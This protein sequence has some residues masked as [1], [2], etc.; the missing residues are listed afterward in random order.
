[1]AQGEA[2]FDDRSH[3][4][5]SIEF[6]RSSNGGP[7][8]R[9]HEDCRRKKR[10][11][12]EGGQELMKRFGEA[13]PGPTHPPR[14]F[15][16]ICYQPLTF[17]M[18][19]NVHYVRFTD[20]RNPLPSLHLRRKWRLAVHH[21][22]GQWGHFSTLRRRGGIDDPCA[23]GIG[24]ASIHASG[25]YVANRK[26]DPTGTDCSRPTR[27]RLPPSP[28]ALPAPSSQIANLTCWVRI[29]SDGGHLRAAS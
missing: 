18:S 15:R 22:G 10:G 7:G 26:P 5:H 9:G 4:H 2:R 27:Y 1:V 6:G 28:S 13:T 17:P 29:A 21:N 16:R 3:P 8:N 25:A 11:S 12:A 19:D 23:I 24:Q 14:P 20:S